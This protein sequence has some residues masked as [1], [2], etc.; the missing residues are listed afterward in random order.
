NSPLQAQVAG[1]YQT[2]VNDLTAA[3]GLL[4]AAAGN[5][6]IHMQADGAM[7]GPGLLLSGMRTTMP[8]MGPSPFNDAT[9]LFGVPAG[10]PGVLAVAGTNRVTT[11]G[12]PG[13]TKFGQYG[14]GL[15]NQLAFY[16]NYGEKIALSAPGGSTN[17][18]VPI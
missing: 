11:A 1:A 10:I 6:H 7:V 12:A 14:M 16:S 18:N 5:D 13:E 8:Q 3:G 4:I 17:Y 15:G 9:G 2:K